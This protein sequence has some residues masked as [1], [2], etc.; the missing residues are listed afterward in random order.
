MVR[1]LLT[2]VISAF[3]GV[4]FAG[5]RENSVIIGAAQEPTVIGDLLAVLGSQAIAAEHNLWLFEGLYTIDLD[6]NL[7]P[8]LATEVATVE[9]GR[10]VITADAEGTQIV[11]MRLT[12]RDDIFWSDGVAITTRDLELV[13]DIVT[14]PGVSLAAIS[15]YQRFSYKTIDE[16][17]FVVTL[18][19]AQSSDLAGSPMPVLPAHVMQAPW[20]A[21]KAA[22]EGQDPQRKTEIFR[23]VMTDFGSASGINSGRAVFSGAFKAVRWVPGSGMVFERNASYYDHPEDQ[24]SYART[25]EYRYL[26]DTNAL[27]F[28]IMVG[29]VD[30]VSSVSISFD[31]AL[32]PQVASGIDDSYDIWFVPGAVWEHLEINQFSNV[33][34]VADNMLDDL[35]TRKAIVHAIDR[36]GM[37]DALFEGL[38]PVSHSNVSPGDPTYNPDVP[39]YAYDPE[40]AKAY[41]ADLGWTPGPDGILR[42]TTADGR[43]VRFEFEFV[44]T[45]GNAV[46]ERQQ[47]FIA[48]DLRAVG[49]D[50]RINN[51]PSNVVFAN[52]FINRAYDGAWTGTFMF[53]WVSSQ[54]SSLNAATYVCRFA[55][56]PENGFAGQNAGGACSERYDALRDQAVAELDLVVSLPIY[57]EMQVV[58]A[59][60]LLAIP[61]I[62]RS[63]P[64][65]TSFG[66]VNYVTSTFGNG[67]GYPPTRPALVGWTANGATKR[68][69]Q[70]DYATQYGF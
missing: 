11:S 26:N 49:I 48:E 55:P 38:Q 62:F 24:A 65:V 52:E 58:Y 3:I 70:A 9:N 22:A 13:N 17:N 8:G 21:A 7:Q 63:T 36:Q 46:R 61:L 14:T 6:A 37:T 12:L 57:Q 28:Q 51:A 29:A 40:L 45:A 42:R 2:L 23:T 56:T 54:S 68:F 53:A 39:Q 34:A 16:R 67:N 35:R 44:T 41:L 43:T 66:L 32:S 10:L 25:V 59:E 47:Q 20:T 19:P 33:Q 15:Y 64:Y 1:F 31:Q 18:N 27:L 5:P 30:T 60:E 69:D 50:V 4:G